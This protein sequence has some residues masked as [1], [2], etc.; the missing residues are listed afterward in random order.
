MGKIKTNKAVKGRFKL[1]KNKK[2][3]R[4]HPLRSH[5]LTKKSSKR[6]RRLK[7]TGLVSKGHRKVYLKMI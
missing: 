7:K 5:L 1:T 2:L 4:M 6:K 3:K